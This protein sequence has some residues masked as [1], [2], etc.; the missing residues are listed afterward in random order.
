METPKKIQG[1]HLLTLRE[2]AELLHVHPNTLRLW[3]EKGILKSVRIGT[4]QHRRYRRID[5]EK[6]IK[7][8]K[9]Q[10]PAAPRY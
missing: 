3:D 2:T 9:V 4:A 1:P 8:R 5:I 10:A 6:I 7:N